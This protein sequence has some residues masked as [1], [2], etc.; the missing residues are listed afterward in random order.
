MRL[1]WIPRDQRRARVRRNGLGYCGCA[2]HGGVGDGSRA[3]RSPPPASW[4]RSVVSAAVRAMTHQP[5][6]CCSS[7]SAI[8]L[9]WPGA[10]RGTLQ[11]APSL[12]TRWCHGAADRVVADVAPPARAPLPACVARGTQFRDSPRRGER[13]RCPGKPAAR[14]RARDRRCSAAPAGQRYL[15]GVR[16]S[17]RGLEGLDRIALCLR[18]V[19]GEAGRRSRRSAGGASSL[20]GNRAWGVEHLDLIADE[21]ATRTGI[22]PRT[23]RAYLG[24]LD[25]Q[26]S[27][28]HLAG[29]TEFFGR[30]A[31]DGLVPNGSLTFLTAA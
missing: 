22:P 2:G 19:G 7:T 14:C 16:G 8:S 28:R 12:R 13:P 9:R 3:Q 26:L 21:A 31:N 24:D 23:C 18:G 27:Y 15:S 30:L 17:R 5:I 4:T 6:T 29:L 10:Q 25:Y 11:Q 20:A 1:G